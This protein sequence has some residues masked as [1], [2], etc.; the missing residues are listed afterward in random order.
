MSLNPASLRSQPSRQPPA[1]SRFR[2]WDPHH[3]DNQGRFRRFACEDTLDGLLAWTALDRTG[4]PAERFF[5][6]AAVM[7]GTMLMASALWPAALWPTDSAITLS[8]LV[9]NIARLR[10]RFYAG[11]H[12]SRTHGPRGDRLRREAEQT[13][14]PLGGTR[15][16]LNQALAQEA[17]LE[18]QERHLSL[19][20]A[21]LGYPEAS[22][23]RAKTISTVSFR[24]A[25]VIR[26]KITTAEI[27]NNRGDLPHA[28]EQLAEAED[29]LHRGIACG[30]SPTVVVLLGFQGLYPLFQAR[31]D[32]IHDPRVDEL[33]DLVGDLFGAYSQAI[34]EVARRPKPNTGIVVAR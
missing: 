27:L 10:D 17:M 2:E 14:Q 23:Q 13:G 30:L 5:D 15:Q 24:L 21:A 22:R 12:R 31:E 25:A 3:I 18:L 28:A 9:P 19:L 32:A 34:G 1:Q 16:Y 6:A 33:L 7:A 8:T 29:V 4:D 26:V 11:R 20:F